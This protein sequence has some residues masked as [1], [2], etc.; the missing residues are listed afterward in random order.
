[1]IVKRNLNSRVDV[2]LHFG[3]AFE[4][5]YSV[6]NADSLIMIHLNYC[7]IYTLLKVDREILIKR[8]WSKKVN[9]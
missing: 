2:S 3:K 8:K 4:Y 1:M 7:F 5:H 6:C 9:P